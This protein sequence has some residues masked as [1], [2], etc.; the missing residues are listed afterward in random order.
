MPLWF[1]LPP[2]ARLISMTITIAYCISFLG[3]IS[4]KVQIYSFLFHIR[5]FLGG[6]RGN[7]LAVFIYVWGIKSGYNKYWK[8]IFDINFWKNYIHPLTPYKG[9][10]RGEVKVREEGEV[11]GKEERNRGLRK[12]VL[13]RRLIQRLQYAL[14]RRLKTEHYSTKFFMKIHQELRKLGVF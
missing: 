7:A 4:C 2:G 10:K 3:N 5:G 13:P 12:M 11:R 9:L 14:K 1:F 8:F 6:K